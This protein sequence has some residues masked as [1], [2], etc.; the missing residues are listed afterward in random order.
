[1]SNETGSIVIDTPEGIAAYRL[2]TMRSALHL[3]V[4]C[5]GMKA[6]RISVSKV[7]KA[8]LGF[9]GNK[10]SLLKQLEDYMEDTKKMVLKTRYTEKTVKK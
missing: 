5:P 2:L 7:V 6:S 8:E 3:E 9:K 4:A 1:M 10:A